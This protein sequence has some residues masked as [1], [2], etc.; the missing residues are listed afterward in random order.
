MLN[1]EILIQWMNA[2]WDDSVVPSLMEYIRIPNQSP[3]FDADWEA[4]GFMKQAVMHIA[5]WCEAQALSGFS[6]EVIQEAGRTPLILMEIAGQ[7]ADTVLM[8][9]HLDKQ[10]P[11]EG[12]APGLGPW[13]PVMRGEKLYGRGGADDGYAAYA[14]LLAVKALQEQGI[15]HPRIV[16][17]IEASEESGSMDLPFYV[18]RLKSRLG[19][20]KLVVCLDSG[21]GNF[22]QLW[23]T[24]SLRGNIIAK[25]EVEVLQ[26]GMH[27][28]AASGI[29]PDSFRIAR[30]LLER[31]E[32]AES[33]RFLLPE[34]WV[35]IPNERQEQ[36][37]HCADVLGESYLESFSWANPNSKPKQPLAELLLNRTW[38]PQMT[39]T[40]ADGLPPTALA[41]NVLR[42]KTTL[43]LSL[44]IPPTAQPDAIASA[45]KMALEKDAPAAVLVHCDIEDGSPGWNAPETAAWLAKAS[46]EASQAFFGHSA[47]YFGEGGTIPFMGMLGAEFPKAQFLVTGVLGPKTNAHGPNE[48]LHIPMAKK[49]SCCVAYIL[50]ELGRSAC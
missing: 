30:Q 2:R 6:L 44:R 14:S 34:A 43:K 42:P 8:Y 37:K 4:H 39:V 27:S 19:T 15:A 10:P 12:W 11:M 41:G 22:E 48:F 1:K 49:L 26:E 5:S 23:V 29:V 36:A 50:S 45:L 3:H 13:E 46:Q 28:G 32:Q 7:T 24:T 16:I 40:G 38:R 25:L 20:P 31:I 17:L 35:D 18:A 33:G 47:A 21:A 9:G